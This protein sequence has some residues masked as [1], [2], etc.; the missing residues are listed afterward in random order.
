MNIG[1]IIQARMSASRLRGKVLMDLA[2]KPVLWHVV[3]RCRRSKLAGKVIV[4]TSVDPTD[5]AIADF[6]KNNNINAFRGS[7]LDVLD[8]FHACALSSS[9]DVIVRV[10]ADCP[11][12]DPEVIDQSIQLFLDNTVGYVSNVLSRDFPRGLDCE[13]F[14]A[15]A[16][17]EAARQAS[18]PGQREHV[19]PYIK[20]HN[21]ILV[22][23]MPPELKGDFRL[24]LDE[25]A[26]YELL[27]LLYEKFY[28]PDKN[29]IIN[30]AAVITFLGGHPELAATNSMVRQKPL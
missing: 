25:Q 28:Q 26:D 20:S 11:L 13:V 4:A 2:G 9:L 1:I 16:L 24:T 5:D 7:L 21:K 22:C 27:K 17:H 15:A 19:T 10:T 14:S 8:R 6:C 23:T 3:E 29:Y 12:I 30:T 18:E